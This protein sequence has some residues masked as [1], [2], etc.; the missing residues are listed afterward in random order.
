MKEDEAIEGLEPMADDA[1]V[2]IP[3]IQLGV[4]TVMPLQ[5]DSIVERDMENILLFRSGERLKRQVS[6]RFSC[7]SMGHEN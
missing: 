4:F 5:L 7:D 1:M 6:L 3:L 2:R